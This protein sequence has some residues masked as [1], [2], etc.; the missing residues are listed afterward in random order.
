MQDRFYQFLKLNTRLVFVELIQQKLESYSCAAK[1]NV[2][3]AAKQPGL[4][5][6][7]TL[8]TPC[9]EQRKKIAAP[10]KNQQIL[11]QDFLAKCLANNQ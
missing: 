4:V 9:K 8:N 11:T 1:F 10:V 5:V 6:E 2:V 3:N 7:S